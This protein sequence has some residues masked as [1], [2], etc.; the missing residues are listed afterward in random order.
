MRKSIL[1]KKS[2]IKVICIVLIFTMIS[3]IFVFEFGGRINTPEAE[4]TTLSNGVTLIDGSQVSDI[5]TSN[6]VFISQFDA[7]SQGITNYQFINTSDNDGR[8]WTDKSVNMNQAFIYDTLGGVAG[9]ETSSKP[10]EFLVTYS[11]L[12]QSVNITNII[13]EPSDTVF[14]IDVSGSMV[15]NTV[16]GTSPLQTRI[17]VVVSALNDAIGML[18]DAN[19]NNR[20]AVVIYGGQSVSGSNYARAQPILELG[21]YNTASPIFSMS[22]TSTVTVRSGSNVSGTPAPIHSSFTVEGGTPTQLGMR[23]GAQVLLDVV[24]GLGGGSGTQFETDVIDPAT[25]SNMI[26]TRQPNII[27]MTDG[28]PTFAWATNYRLDDQ[29]HVDGSI[30]TYDVGNGSTGDMGLTA[31]TVM[32][33]S[34]VKQRVQEWYYPTN[35]SAPGYRPDNATRAVGFYTLGLGVNSAIANGMLDP[36]GISSSGVPNAQLVTQTVGSQTF[37][38]LNILNQ[39]AAANTTTPITFPAIQKGASTTNPQRPNVTVNNTYGVISCNYDTMSFTA[40]DKAGLDDAFNTITQQIVSQGNYSTD[41]GG[42]DPQFRGYLGFSDVLGQYM[43][44]GEFRGLYYNNLKYDGTEFA[45]AITTPTP[46]TS[47]IRTAFLEGLV[48]QIQA[49][50]LTLNTPTVINP[51]LAGALLDSN[52][53]NT[54]T[55]NNIISYYTDEN[56]QFLGSVYYPSGGGLIDFTTVPGAKAKVDMYIVHFDGAVDSEQGTA[57]DLMYIIFQVITILEDGQFASAN[58]T[59]PNLNLSPHLLAGDQIVRWYIPAALIPLRKVDPVM[60]GN[61]PVLDDFGNPVYNILE[62]VPL[63]TIFTVMPNI[64]EI[65]NGV[66]AEYARVNAGPLPNSYFFYANRWRG[67]DGT[68]QRGDLA[69]MSLAFFTAHPDND[70]YISPET[71]GG[72]PKLPIPV[73]LTGTAPFAWDFSHFPTNSTMQVQR[74]GNNGRFLVQVADITLRLYKTFTTNGVP[75]EIPSTLINPSFLIYGQDEAGDEIYRRT[76]LFS[77]L[78][79]DGTGTNTFIIDIS[80]PPGSYSFTETGGIAFGYDF[81]PPIPMFLKLPPLVPVT[82]SINYHNSYTDDP[83]TGLWLYK[84]FNGL[85]PDEIPDNFTMTLSGPEGGTRA[86]TTY[87]MAQLTAGVLTDVTEPGWYTLSEANADV[88]PFILESVPELPYRFEVLSTDLAPNGRMITISNTY[89]LPPPPP[90]YTLTL[91][92]SIIPQ[93]LPLETVDDFGNTVIINQEPLDLAFKVEQKDQATWNPSNPWNTIFLATIN[94][95]DLVNGSA[96]V[97]GLS[98]GTY[99]LTEVGGVV[100]GYNGPTVTIAPTLSRNPEVPTIPNSYLL[101][102]SSNISVTF[103]NTYSTPPPPPSPPPSPSPQ[104]GD[105]RSTLFPILLLS[106]GGMCVIIGVGSGIGLYRA[107]Q[108]SK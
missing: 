28:E 58:T 83:Q 61:N 102:L 73:G 66:T 26:V 21:R 9:V 56:R 67:L 44:F 7:E 42:G 41:V 20:I 13:V 64:E 69:N 59:D 8:V 12:S 33:A 52:I 11:A 65:G 45:Q 78:V 4:A 50:N 53:A 3:S 54:S 90:T 49:Q 85:R 84:V 17:Q 48:N 25:G 55:T 71:M 2:F 101:P 106:F 88:P 77:E 70:Y 37:N 14:V 63:R 89:T 93:N 76:V 10:E 103:T 91:N 34:Y 32:T 79:D 81:T 96:Q 57:T 100:D 74:L 22:G 35:P 29:A 87:T 36:Y 43:E 23:R 6:F 108:K 38:M 15:S 82:P 46:A 68:V 75:G 107:R 24:Q 5:D 16:P 47:P 30:F 98:A 1:Y 72:I 94:Y 60:D 51:T 104:T 97:T 40:M 99:T 39:F 95:P 62:A 86:D 92:K 27:L 80:V 31:L 19:P 18:M 105:G